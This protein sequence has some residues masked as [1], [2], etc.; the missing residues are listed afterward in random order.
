MTFSTK[1]EQKGQKS[2]SRVRVRVRIGLGLGLLERCVYE[3]VQ[4][5]KE[6]VLYD[7]A[8]RKVVFVTD[9]TDEIEMQCHY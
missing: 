3:L 4:V 9:A 1:W 8:G 7:I 5:M 6:C 2:H